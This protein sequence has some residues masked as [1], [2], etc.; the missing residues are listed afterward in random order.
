MHELVFFLLQCYPDNSRLSKEDQI[1][2]LTGHDCNM[3]V[4]Q[5]ENL[6]DSALTGDI[7]VIDL[8]ISSEQMKDKFLP[9]CDEVCENKAAEIKVQIEVSFFHTHYLTSR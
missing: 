5:G 6:M 3:T 1:E 4:D 7:E 8:I 9:E 2:V